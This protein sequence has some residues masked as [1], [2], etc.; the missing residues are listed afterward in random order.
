MQTHGASSS[1]NN[2]RYHRSAVLGVLT[3]TTYVDLDEYC[4]RPQIEEWVHSLFYPNLEPRYR[5]HKPVESTRNCMIQ[6]ALAHRG[7]PELDR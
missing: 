1:T 6:L 4:N 7:S 5:R 2:P 3:R